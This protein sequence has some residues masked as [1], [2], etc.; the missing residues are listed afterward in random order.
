MEYIFRK[1]KEAIMWTAYLISVRPKSRN[2]IAY[3]Q[4]ASRI[5]KKRK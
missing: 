3:M 4:G 5:R 1:M 2:D